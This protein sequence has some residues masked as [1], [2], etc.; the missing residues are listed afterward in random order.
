MILVLLT[1]VWLLSWQ[2]QTYV[3]YCKTENDCSH[4]NLLP[5]ALF[6]IAEFFHNYESV[7]LV[8]ST[9]AIAWFT[10]E[11][12]SATVGLKDSTD[13]LWNAGKSQIALIGR[14]TDLAEKQH[15]LAREEYFAS[16][17]PRI[18]LRRM[19]TVLVTEQ[20][21]TVFFTIVNT[22]ETT[23]KNCA[24]NGQMLLLKRAG[25]IHTVIGF[26]LNGMDSYNEPLRVGEGINRV[27]LD[28]V[29]LVEI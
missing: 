20:P 24:W 6:E 16:H 17:R 22:G 2:S 26:P 23:I 12:R 27:L 13:K 29:T 15:G 1:S 8:L 25:K 18:M 3:E 5:F 7:F 9:I 11:L 28:R 19:G 4:Y 21:T 14:Q 10:L